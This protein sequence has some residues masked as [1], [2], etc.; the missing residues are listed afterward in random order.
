[1]TQDLIVFGIIALTIGYVFFS[2]I[3]NIRAKKE[4]NG[5]GGCNGCELSKSSAACDR[6]IF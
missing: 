3:K 1:M 5:C 2:F 6:K 4:N